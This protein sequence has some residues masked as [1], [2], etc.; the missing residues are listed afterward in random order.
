MASTP[1]RKLSDQETAAINTEYQA[2]AVR[3]ETQCA[4]QVAF[5]RREITTDLRLTTARINRLTQILDQGGFKVSLFR[6]SDE[7]ALQKLSVQVV[8]AIDDELDAY[9]RQADSMLP[10]RLVGFLD[11]GVILPESKDAA[12]DPSPLL[13]KTR[14]GIK[15]YDDV[16]EQRK[17]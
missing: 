11:G 5:L 10:K 15:K 14:T 7:N 13:G 2:L 8:Y 17:K 3:V 12:T 9:L 1:I 4:E 16:L 6:M